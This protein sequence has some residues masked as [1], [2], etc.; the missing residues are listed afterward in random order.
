MCVHISAHNSSTYHRTVL[1]IFPLILQTNHHS[2]DAVCGEGEKAEIC[3]ILIQ[4][5]KVGKFVQDQ[6][7]QTESIRLD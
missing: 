7:R 6:W 1:I 2:L 4:D 5:F 3:K